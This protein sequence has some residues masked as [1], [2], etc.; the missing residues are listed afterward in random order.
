MVA[1]LRTFVR[2]LASGR[3]RRFVQVNGHVRAAGP[4]H[5]RITGGR[6]HMRFSGD[7][8]AR[9]VEAASAA[10][11]IHN[12]QPWH[13]EAAGDELRL[14]GVSDRA[15]SVCDPDARALYISCGTA[16]FNA[17]L[18]ARAAGIDCDVSCLPH[19]EYPFGVLAVMR[20]RESHDPSPGELRLYESIW[21]RHTDRRPFSTRHIPRLLVAA[22]RKSAGGEGACLRP[23]GR[24]DAAIVLDLAAQAGRE[25]A[26]DREHQNELRRWLR[27]GAEDGI[28]AWALPVAPQHIPSPVRDAD[29]LAAAGHISGAH[30]AYERHPQLAVLTT[31]Q[32]EPEDWLRAGEALQHVLLVATLNGVSASFLYQL[33][34]RDDMREGRER[35]WPWPEHPQMIIRLGYGAGTIPTP[36][37]SSADALEPTE[38]L[39]LSG[40]T[41]RL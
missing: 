21:K 1:E 8:T 24:R 26:A 33:I 31:G 16:L 40:M 30:G 18:A 4:V 39:Q 7:L 41:S 29:L 12:S 17:R 2:G 35:S 23:L 6:R 25:L 36:R 28:P 5:R 19:P 11:S 37:R 14:H 27:D 13:F 15:L 3:A 32:D 22:M 34:E 9:V 20:A 10:P 38:R